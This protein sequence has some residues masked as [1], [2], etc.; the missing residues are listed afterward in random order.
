VR[1][2][3]INCHINNDK[4][5]SDS[6]IEYDRSYQIESQVPD[7]GNILTYISPPPPPVPA[8]NSVCQILSDTF[9]YIEIP[10]VLVCWACLGIYSW[11]H[12]EDLWFCQRRKLG[13]FFDILFIF[14]IGRFIGGIWKLFL[15]S[16]WR[17]D[18]A[19]PPGRDL[20]LILGPAFV[21]ELDTSGGISTGVRQNLSDMKR[22]MNSW[23]A[24]GCKSIEP[25]A[26]NFFI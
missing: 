7:M 21:R 11:K 15:I 24:F 13:R 14:S 3:D 12:S 17:R 2:S 8:K 23:M 6:K 4:H 16:G 20:N 5:Y 25:L 9:A 19:D 10:A 1:D 18:A 22:P 26:L